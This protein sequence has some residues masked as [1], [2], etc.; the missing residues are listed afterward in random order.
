M[1]GPN[2]LPVVPLEPPL[3]ANTS[4][5]EIAA[6]LAGS[7]EI[8]LTGFSESRA[9]TAAWQHPNTPLIAAGHYERDLPLIIEQSGRWKKT[10]RAAWIFATACLAFAAGTFISMLA[11]DWSERATDSV[12]AWSITGFAGD[13]ILVEMGGKTTMVPMGARLPNGELVVQTM[14]DKRLILLQSSTI[15]LRPAAVKAPAQ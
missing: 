1:Q 7:R 11:V 4:S 10:V 14:P 13:G 6:I 8:V 2:T 3:L 9:L 5:Y 15:Y 12:A